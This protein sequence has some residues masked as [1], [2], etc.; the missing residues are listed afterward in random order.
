MSVNHR[1]GP[2]REYLICSLANGRSLKSVN[3][4][5]AVT[6]FIFCTINLK[7]TKRNDP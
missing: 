2:L 6:R 3:P 4:T 1:K 5:Q 7:E